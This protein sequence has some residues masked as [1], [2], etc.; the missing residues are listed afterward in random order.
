MIYYTRKLFIVNTNF[1]F[2]KNLEV[3]IILN[4]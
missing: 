1:L 4:I 3:F 2:I